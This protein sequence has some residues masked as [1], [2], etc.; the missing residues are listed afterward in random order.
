MGFMLT[1]LPIWPED[2][3]YTAL[4]LSRLFPSRMELS[5]WVQRCYEGRI[6]TRRLE[7]NPVY[8]PAFAE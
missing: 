3:R 1:R 4:M 8:Q 7:T 5:K 2:F 6:R